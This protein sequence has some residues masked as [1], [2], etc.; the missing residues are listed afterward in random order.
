MRP[1]VTRGDIAAASGCS[2]STVR[3]KEKEWG[4][5]DCVSAATKHPK[6]F[7]TEQASEALIKRRVIS[8]PLR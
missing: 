2:K 7:F 8:R 1:T 3:R 4:L 6:Q 5:D